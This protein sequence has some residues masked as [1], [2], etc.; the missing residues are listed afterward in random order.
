M[1]YIVASKTNPNESKLK[2]DLC[3][4]DTLYEIDMRE[5]HNQIKILNAK[6]KKSIKRAYAKFN[7]PLP[8]KHKEPDMS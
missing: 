3:E 8:K 4:I 7:V 6:R 5:I 1:N 2:D